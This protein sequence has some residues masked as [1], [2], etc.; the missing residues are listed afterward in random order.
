MLKRYTSYKY[1]TSP[2]TSGPIWHLYLGSTDV[3]DGIEDN[4]GS[5]QVT[6]RKYIQEKL[7]KSG[8]KPFV[9]TVN[10]SSVTPRINRAMAGV[11]L[12]I[13]PCYS[14]NRNTFT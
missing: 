11:I 13:T 5:Y 2:H 12:E 9:S 14:G 8:N 6:L 10:S 7:L 4:A 3:M 1:A